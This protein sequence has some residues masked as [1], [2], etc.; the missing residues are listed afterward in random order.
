ML[1]RIRDG[2]HRNKWL[3]YVVLGALALVFAAWGAYGIV[4][5]NFDT[6][7]YA[8]DADGQKIPIQQARNAWSHEEAR[9]Q[10]SFRGQDIPAFMRE[11][12]QDQVL[13]GLIRDALMTERTHDLGYRITEA[14]VQEAVRNEPAFQIEGKYSPE[15]AKAALAQAGLSV[16][17]FETEL[18]SQLQRTQL[19]NGIRESDFLTPREIAQSQALQNEQREVRYAVLPADKFPGAPVDDAAV[20]A[21]YKSH[22]AEFMTPE[23]AH[24]QYAELRLDQLAAQMPVT[25]ADLHDAY[26]KNKASYVLPE[27]RH[28]HHILIALSKDDAADRKLADDVYQQAKAGKDFGQLAKQYSKDPGSAQKG[29]DLDW[30]DRTSFVAPFS[31]AL[32]SMNVGEIHPP[33][34]TQYGYHI[35]RLD[36]IQAGK[37]KTFEEARPELET[38]VRRNHGTDR[39]GEIQEQLQTR[40]EQQSGADLDAVAKEFKLQ[41]GDVPQFLRGVGAAPLG[42]APPLQDLVFGDSAVAP[43]HLG[44]PVL[45]GDDRLALVKVLDRKKPEPKALTEVHDSIVATLKK[46]NATEAAEKAAEAAKE[47]LAAGSS[48]DEIAKGLGVTA[49]PARFVGRS[50]PAVPAQIRTLVFDVS[51]PAPDKPVFRTVKLDSGGAAVVAVTKFRVDTS[52]VDKQQQA[53]LTKQE[54]ARQGANDAMAYLEDVR[55]GAKVIKN[56]KAFE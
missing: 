19:E 44:G 46:Q 7:S 8:A 40:L 48:F 20:Q 9:L 14:D 33:V 3:G 24:V 27:R 6:A 26:E 47:K 31:D 56:P 28:A 17:Q 30:A 15:A 1:Q 25:D 4:N 37:T 35:I 11:R 18:R 50:D 13:E 43:G 39:F 38:E 16:E 34:K 5:I 54:V 2:L 12:F 36:E 52:G 10:Q 42:A 53:A 55:H 45:L 49:E 41:T 21:Y 23:S 32:F 51:K 22:Q 29:G